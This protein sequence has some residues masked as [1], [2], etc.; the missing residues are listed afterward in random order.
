L[1]SLKDKDGILVAQSS[2]KEKLG[3]ENLQRVINFA[4]NYMSGIKLPKKRGNFVELRNGILNL[5]IVGRSCSQEERKEFFEYD[6]IHKIREEFVQALEE[7]LKDLDLQFAIGG[8]IS[9][10]CFPKGWSKEYC[11]NSIPETFTNVF[12]YGD[13]CFQGG[14]DY[15]IYSHPRTIASQ[16]SGPDSTMKFLSAQFDLD[17]NIE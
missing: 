4:L 7:N 3:E 16:V 10:D 9:I 11:L 12:F 14:N 17:D 8:E 5:A 1:T 15:E 6:R 13:K 2:I